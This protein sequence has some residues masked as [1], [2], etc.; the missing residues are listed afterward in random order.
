[1]AVQWK[2]NAKFFIKTSSVVLVGERTTPTELPA[3]VG[4]VIINFCG[5]R[6]SLGQRDESLLP[7]SR[8]SRPDDTSISTTKS[9]V[10]ARH[11]YTYYY[12]LS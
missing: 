11:F 7:Y 8:F 9:G 6:V 2:E 5:R 4:E 12:S 10:N 1:M 3:L